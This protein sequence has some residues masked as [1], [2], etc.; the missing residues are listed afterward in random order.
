MVLDYLVCVFM[1]IL[2]SPNVFATPKAM[3]DGTIFDSDYYA[4]ANPDVVAAFGN[5]EEMLWQHYQKWGKNEG[6]MPFN[7]FPAMQASEGKTVNGTGMSNSV[8]AVNR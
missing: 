4:A 5:S 8:D 3:E 1:M 7:L 2:I 6:R